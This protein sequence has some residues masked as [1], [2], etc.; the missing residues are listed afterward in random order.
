MKPKIAKDDHPKPWEVT[1]AERSQH[2]PTHAEAIRY[3]AE[4]ALRLRE[5]AK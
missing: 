2:F 5:G 3:A 1:C 4:L